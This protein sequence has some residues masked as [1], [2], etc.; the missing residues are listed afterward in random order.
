MPCEW[1][2][3]SRAWAGPLPPPYIE[4]SLAEAEDVVAAVLNGEADAALSD[5]LFLDDFVA[6]SE[7]KLIIVGQEVLLDKGTG[8]GVRETDGELKRKLDEAIGAMKEDGSLNTLIE[9]WFGA[10][11]QTF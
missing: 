5:K 2:A 3:A 1:P 4:T 11:A 9:K 8:I 7:G 10:D 6:R